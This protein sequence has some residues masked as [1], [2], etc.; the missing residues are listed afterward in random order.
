[1][2]NIINI[3]NITGP[4]NIVRLEGK[5][6]NKTK[7]LYLLGDIHL[8]TSQQTKC[9]DFSSLDILQI[10][11]KFVKNANSYKDKT[12]DIFI[13]DNISN[14]YETNNLSENTTNLNINKFTVLDYYRDY[15]NKSISIK[16]SIYIDK[17]QDFIRYNFNKNKNN[18]VKVSDRYKNIRYHYFDIRKETEFH[19]IYFNII[20]TIFNLVN[21]INNIKYE[22]LVNLIEQLYSLLLIDYN[23]FFK[24]NCKIHKCIF[25]LKSSYKNNDIKQ[26]ILKILNSNKIKFNKILKNVLKFLKLIK[27]KKVTENNLISKFNRK[28]NSYGYDVNEF[29][30]LKL[31]FIK[32]IDINI[33]H[34]YSNITDL[35]FLRRFLDKNY[36]S[37]SIIYC[38][39]NHLVH[40]SYVLIYF[41]NFN[42]TNISYAKVDLKTLNNNFKSSKNIDDFIKKYNIN[43]F[44]DNLIQCSSMKEFPDMFL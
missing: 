14:I 29:Q 1:M 26:L 10:F 39:Y 18:L 7:I 19:N 13:E 4:L 6:N 5:I 2:K 31:L 21:D 15:I 35:Y 33:L 37:N 34:V 16:N 43:I 28:I 27:S 11:D 41:F 42:I 38:G 9:E 17:I 22:N 12:W 20:P 30:Q 32:S 23:K 3:P 36:I 25:K 40:I 24:Q 8:N 44:P